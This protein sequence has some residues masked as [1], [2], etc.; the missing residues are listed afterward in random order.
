MDSLLQA[1]ALDVYFTPVQMKKNRPGTLLTVICKLADASALTLLTLMETSTLGVRRY[2][3]QRFSLPRVVRT[4]ETE[5]GPIDV[6]VATLPGGKLRAAP[7]Y[8]SC[9]RAALAHQVPLWEVYQAALVS[10]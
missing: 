10:I 2:D 6:K 4:V 7:E 5:F 8:E 3:V 1:G 9:L